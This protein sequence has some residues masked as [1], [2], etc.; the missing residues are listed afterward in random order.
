M[1]MT[2]LNIK[3]R[4][5]FI[6]FIFYFLFNIPQVL[7]AQSYNHNS[8]GFVIKI[9]AGWDLNVTLKGLELSHNES[10]LSFEYLGDSKVSVADIMDY[11]LPKDKEN[12][13]FIGDMV[14]VKKPY[15]GLRTNLVDKGYAAEIAVLNTPFGYYLLSLEQEKPD[16]KNK[17]LFEQMLKDFALLDTKPF[18]ENQDILQSVTLGSIDLG[19]PE[20]ELELKANSFIWESSAGGLLSAEI[21]K[22]RQ[23]LPL[24]VLLDDWENNMLTSSAGLEKRISKLVLSVDSRE[25]IIADYTGDDIKTR[26]H[27]SAIN[28]QSSLM[29]VLITRKKTFASHEQM[30]G[31]VSF[32]I[33]S[34]EDLNKDVFNFS[35]DVSSEIYPEILTMSE[36]EADFTSGDRKLYKQL[37]SGAPDR[38]RAAAKSLYQG[39][40]QNTS[41]LDLAATVLNN[42]YKRQ[43]ASSQ[44]DAMAWI[45][46]ALGKSSQERYLP[47]LKQVERDAPSRKLKK[48]AKK[49][50]LQLR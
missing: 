15:S 48:Y 29:L 30:L 5:V 1:K 11:F 18:D 17:Q 40:Y 10:L 35:S 21:I 32:S 19:V 12:S 2:N 24:I 16:L 6:F 25:A 22:H 38:I 42:G 39:H 33:V 47:L 27:I 23:D 9:P 20:G 37:S 34:S 13:A 31:A 3:L 41:L 43:H 49:A 7:A 44:I 28:K 50:A 14:K 36:S 46:R 45:C 8:A 4:L 26:V